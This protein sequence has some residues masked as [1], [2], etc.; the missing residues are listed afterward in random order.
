MRM[1]FKEK[2]EAKGIIENYEKLRHEKSLVLGVSP[3]HWAY[4]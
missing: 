4:K 2:K 1:L 3:P